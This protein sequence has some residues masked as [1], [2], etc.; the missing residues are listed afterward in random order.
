MVHGTERMLLSITPSRLVTAHYYLLMILLLVA[1]VLIFLKFPGAVPPAGGVVLASCLPLGL[2]IL[3]GILYVIA[4]LK[5]ITHRYY[6]GEANASSKDGIISRRVQ[7]MPYRMIERVEVSQTVAGRIFNLGDLV[8]DSGEEQL[9]FRGIKDPVG[10][11]RQ[12]AQQIQAVT[13]TPSTHV[14]GRPL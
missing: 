4:E 13:G 12:V 8:I 3:C 2:L 14:G 7:Y 9:V 10:V 1:A 6:V 5:R 11:R